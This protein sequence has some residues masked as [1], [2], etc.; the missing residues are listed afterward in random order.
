[1]SIAYVDVETTGLDPQLHDIWEIAWAVDDAPITSAIVNHSTITA[2]AKALEINGYFER[3]DALR[4]EW[5]KVRAE[6]R[7]SYLMGAL[8]GNTLCAANPAFDAGF[9]RARWGQSPWKYR[10]LDIEAYAMGAL[11]YHEPKGLKTI[12]DDLR[13]KFGA[14][15]PE[16]DHTAAGDVATL[17]ACHLELKAIY[18]Q[19]V[20]WMQDVTP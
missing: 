17:R 18:D 19:P 13:A 9:L 10:L 8:E 1:M 5:S 6:T 4:G 20:R 11:G 16:P 15:I 14:E 12:A 2:D 3:L 7:E